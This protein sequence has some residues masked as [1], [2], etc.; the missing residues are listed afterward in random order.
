MEKLQLTQETFPRDILRNVKKIESILIRH[1]AS[2]IILYG[3]LARGD[4]R[5]DS[6]IDVCFEGIPNRK[7]FR[8]VAEI[9]METDRRVSMLNFE[10]AYG[11][12]RERVTKEGK[13]LYER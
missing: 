3:S 10:D 11:H 7:Y 5:V 2:R 6:D 9:L 4:Y 13:V 8:V 1:G 12:F